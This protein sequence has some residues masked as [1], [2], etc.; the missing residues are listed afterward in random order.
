MPIIGTNP[1]YYRDYA[2]GHP[3]MRFGLGAQ[4]MP[5]SLATMTPSQ[6]TATG[7]AICLDQNQN[8]IDCSDPNCTYGDCG[9]TGP[10]LTTGSLCLDQ[11]ENQIACND[12]NCTYG[13]CISAPTTT[14]AAAQ[15]AA[16]VP[17]GTILTYT[18]TIGTSL[19]GTQSATDV[20]S[21]VAGSLPSSG[22]Q[23]TSSN[24]SSQ[25]LTSYI[26]TLT[27]QVTGPGFATT[28]DVQSI[29]DHAFYVQ[30]GQMPMSSNIS[31][32]TG[33]AQNWLAMLEQNWPWIL[34]GLA[35]IVALPAIIKKV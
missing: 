1:R 7:T 20:L 5:L 18:A 29:I 17:T 9:S 15:P 13:D 26:V 31:V 33:G 34:G 8:T 10:Q 35:V 25:G 4:A 32:G 30:K 24:Y 11:N 12:P 3:V 19:L 14:T 28:S 23:V 22:L 16:G 6:A 27:V 21:G 2:S